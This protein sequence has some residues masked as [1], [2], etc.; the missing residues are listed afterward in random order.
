VHR[1][2]CPEN[3]V[4]TGLPADPENPVSTDWT[5]QFKLIGFNEVKSEFSKAHEYFVAPEVIQFGSSEGDSV[6]RDIWAVGVLTYLLFSGDMFDFNDGE[7]PFENE[8]WKDVSIT[9]KDFILS[10][11][12]PQPLSRPNSL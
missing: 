10:L 6:K 7:V 5:T 8:V 4:L 2:I 1:D 11:L 12:T 9:A 3:I